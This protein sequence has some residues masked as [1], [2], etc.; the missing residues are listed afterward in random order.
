MSEEVH[1]EEKKQSEKQINSAQKHK[2]TALPLPPPTQTDLE[3]SF[4]GGWDMQ[5][6]TQSMRKDGRDSERTKRILKQMSMI[7]FQAPIA[8]QEETKSNEEDEE[9]SKFGGK[10]QRLFSIDEDID[11]RLENP[12]SP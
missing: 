6:I 3:D 12:A 9:E 4:Y 7:K 1:G 5:G 8:D 10:P 2:T 11:A